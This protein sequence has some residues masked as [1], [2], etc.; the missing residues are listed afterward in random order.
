VN[1]LARIAAALADPGRLRLLAACFDGE[2]CVCQLVALLGLSNATVSRH[3]TI[4]R[5]AGLLES[6]KQGRWVHYRLPPDPTPAASDA[7]AWVRRGL[8][9]AGSI[10]PDR[11]LMRRI[12]AMDPAEL[13]RMQRDGCCAIP[14]DDTRPAA[15]PPQECCP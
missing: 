14:P 9:T 8:E 12:L 1:D 2:R 7:I 3:L 10:E 11:A 13:C 15:H 6:R 4:L 5:D